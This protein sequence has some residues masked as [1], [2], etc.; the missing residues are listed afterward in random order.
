MVVWLT[1]FGLYEH[2]VQ[3]SLGEKSLLGQAPQYI[4]LVL[5]VIF[6]FWALLFKKARPA[7]PLIYIALLIW[8]A[9][10]LLWSIQFGYTA[11]AILRVFIF[12]IFLATAVSLDRDGI[13]FDIYRALT[14]LLLISFV[15]SALGSHY[16]LMGG[17]HTG[18]WRGF[19]PHKNVLGYISTFYIPFQIYFWKRTSAPASFAMAAVVALLILKA[20]SAT[21]LVVSVLSVGVYFSTRLFR[22]YG[23]VAVTAVILSLVIIVPIVTV[24]SGQFFAFLGRG[25]NLTGRTLIWQYFLNAYMQNPVFG[26]GFGT[27]SFQID[28]IERIRT[29]VRWKALGTPH[30]SYIYIMGELGLVGL[31]LLLVLNFQALLGSIRLLLG[32]AVGLAAPCFTLLLSLAIYRFFES[33]VTFGFNFGMFINVLVVSTVISTL[34]KQSRR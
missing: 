6:I 30:N 23:L 10:S 9:S 27:Q 14:L 32:R 13:W 3:A 15:G 26:T 21:S 28:V 34:P 7:M 8:A 17:S 1:A 16:A 25:E 12:S 4:S 33:S 20:G 2:D 22:R 31:T 19:F 11:S 18:S 5:G 24:L 29:A